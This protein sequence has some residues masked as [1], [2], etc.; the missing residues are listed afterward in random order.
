M[1]TLFRLRGDP[2]FHSGDVLGYFH[3]PQEADEYAKHLKL[4]DWSCGAVE[5]VI[6]EASKREERD[7]LRREL[8]SLINRRSIDARTNTPDFI[9]ADYLLRCLEA[10]TDACDA[11]ELYGRI[12]EDVPKEST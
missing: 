6:A 3:S 4:Q 11:R 2:R 8:A 9:L 5:V 10:F 12:P 1:T 7:D